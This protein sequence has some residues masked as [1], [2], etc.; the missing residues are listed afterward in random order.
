MNRK[1]V[2]VT[3]SSIGLGASII[4]KYASNNY[5]V[6]ITYNTH[7][8]EVLKLKDEI[9]SK[10]KV[11]ALVV[12]CDISNEKDIENLKN[13]ILN[14][15]GKLDVLINNASISMDSILEDKTKDNFMRILEVNLV[16][17]FLLSRC[18]GDIMKNQGYGNIINISS[19]NA[20]DTYYEYS[21]DYDCSK[22]G[23]I[24]LSHNLA[25]YYSPNI[26][27]NTICPG[28]IDTPMNKDMDN[29][30]RKSEENKILLKRFAS[31]NE[32]ANLVYFISSD[33]ASYINDSVIRI[34]GGIKC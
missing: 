24:N 11:N 6:I 26:R 13:E 3:G 23:I 27:V 8:E 5:D 17:T 21:L 31:P 29:D 10:Y 30:F 7:K 4:K 12:K 16:G 18:F 9:I 32:I 34:D 2:L 19:T 33:E 22:A 1:C 25:N 28:W 20:I 15:F 14:I